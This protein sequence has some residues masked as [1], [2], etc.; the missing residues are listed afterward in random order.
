MRIT[1]IEP[2]DTGFVNEWGPDGPRGQFP[3]S[4]LE[5]PTAV[6]GAA[7]D[8]TRESATVTGT[9]EPNGR[10]T[11]L[12]FAY[13]KTT[14]YGSVTATQ[15]V[16]AGDDP[17][18]GTAALSGL[19]P[20]TTY[21]YRVEAIREGGAVAVGGADG[22]F[23]TTAPAPLPDGQPGPDGRARPDRAAFTG[24][25]KVKLAK[26]GRKNR[27][28]TFTFALSEPATVVAVVTRATPGIKKGRKCVAVPKRKP[29]KAK[30]CT[31]Q[32]N[33]ARGTAAA[34]K[35]TLTLPAKGLGNGKYTATL[36]ATDAAGNAG[37]TKVSFTIR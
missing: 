21:H 26:A 20:G 29:K 9:V 35:T 7:G 6:T 12:R 4:G 31:R 3:C 5:I 24:T 32:V 36:T 27:R 30:A 17:V 18:A 33:A 28:A 10:A 34:G 13:G 25:P 1:D 11:G 8:V 23:T 2:N 14:D 37:S 22:T 19:E 16:G 15:D